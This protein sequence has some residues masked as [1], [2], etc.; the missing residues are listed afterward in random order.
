MIF[1]LDADLQKNDRSRSLQIISIYVKIDD[2]RL[3]ERDAEIPLPLYPGEK[4]SPIKHIVFISK[5]NRTYDEVFGQLEKGE[6][7]PTIARYGEN[8]SF[9]NQSKTDSMIN[10]RCD[11]ESSK[12]GKKICHFRQFLCGF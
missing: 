10:S 1:L 7:D 8:V 6:G 12:S 2:P 11:E 5:E 3:K 4:E 9:Y